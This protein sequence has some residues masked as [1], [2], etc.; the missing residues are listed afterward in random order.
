[1]SPCSRRR[2]SGWPRLTEHER[3]GPGFW[4]DYLVRH[5]MLTLLFATAGVLGAQSKN[6]DIYW[7]DVEGGASTLFVSPSGESMLVDTGYETDGRDPKRIMAAAQA[8][9]LTKIDYVVI[10]HYHADHAGGLPGVAKMIPIGKVYGRSDEELEK[11]N[12]K[13]RNNVTEAAKGRRIVVKAGDT[14]PF[15]GVQTTVVISDAKGITKPLKGAGTAN[16]ACKGA[17]QQAAVGPENQR[18][19]GLMVQFGKFRLLNLQDLDWEREMSLVCPIDE[20]GPITLWHASRHGGLDGSGAP[21]LL[22]AIHPQ[23]ILVN[24][25]PRKGM[26]QVDKTVKS[27]TPGGPKPYEKN[28]YL[29]MANLSGV[30]D[31]WQG[32][33]SLL[34]SDTAHNTAQNQIANLEDTADC[35]GN[36]IKA[37]VAPD[38][39][40]TITNG[41]NNFSKT[42]TPR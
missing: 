34:D 28:S 14:I 39:K 3:F 36:W 33:L 42:Y 41:R 12:E 4:G 37:S 2:P 30:E 16:P 25:G 20:L 35:K 26:G 29:R 31:I 13:W 1:M 21:A 24:N 22:S 10:S 9:G 40:F 23:V 7:I 15:K 18:M 17:E 27:T 8:A 5:S 32:H 19:V 38:G 11:A 6:L